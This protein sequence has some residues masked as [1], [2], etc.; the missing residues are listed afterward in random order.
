MIQSRKT[1]ALLLLAT[2][3]F[4]VSSADLF[5]SDLFSGLNKVGKSMGMMQGL[6]KGFTSNKMLRSPI[7][8]TECPKFKSQDNFYINYDTMGGETRHNSH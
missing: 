2:S 5:D 1:S 8:Y 7:T 6:F 4:S 3:L